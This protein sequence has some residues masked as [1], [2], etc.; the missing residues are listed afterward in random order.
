M[1]HPKAAPCGGSWLL[2]NLHAPTLTTMRSPATS[3]EANR[4]RLG[5]CMRRRIPGA[6]ARS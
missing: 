2:I 5:T 4:S 6:D 1:P 3:T